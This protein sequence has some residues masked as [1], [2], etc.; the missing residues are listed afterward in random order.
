MEQPIA[1]IDRNLELMSGKLHDHIDGTGPPSSP[2]SCNL[3]H[4]ILG[5]KR[6]NILRWIST[7]EDEKHHRQANENMLENTGQWLLNK[8]QFREWQ[9]A[10]ASGILWLH[11][12]R[13]LSCALNLIEFGSDFWAAGAGKTKLTYDNLEFRRYLCSHAKQFIVVRLLMFSVRRLKGMSL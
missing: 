2:R 8:P 11:G 10:S 6:R 5:E 4:R 13:K 9:C 7:S 12:I 1:R 3:F